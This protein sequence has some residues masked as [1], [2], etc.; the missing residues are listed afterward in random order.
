M[1]N[2]EG[3]TI[4]CSRCGEPMKS[5]ARYCMKCGNLNSN[6]EANKNMMPYIK[7]NDKNNNTYQIG[8]GKFIVGQNQSNQSREAFANNTGNKRVCFWLNYVIFIFTLL[9]AFLISKDSITD[10]TTLA[11]SPL[12]VVAIITSLYFLYVYSIELIFMK[13]NKPWWAW[14]IPVYNL[15][16]LGEIT[17]QNKKI[18]LIGLIPIIGQI[19]F[20][21]MIYKLGTQ[22]KYSGLLTVLF[23]FIFIPIIGFGSNTYDGKT[24]ITGEEKELE[25]EYKAKKIFLSTIIL[26]LGA[27]LVLMVIANMSSVE[28]SKQ[29]FGNWY[30]VSASK[31]IVNKIDKSIDKGLISCGNYEYSNTKGVYYFRFRDLSDEIY[32]PLSLLREEIDTYVKVDNNGDTTKYY[33][34][35]SD[36]TYGFSETLIDEVDMEK[37]TEYK[38]L[39]FN[40]K[41]KVICYING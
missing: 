10:F 13:C 38:Q 27:G 33:I 17:F 4:Y 24:Y 8:S 25:K 15:M 1:N 18:G 12:P 3:Y 16:I 31:R 7:D 14:F 22:F 30:Y 28:K 11:I 40:D 35:M 9:I 41:G 19:F 34:S 20:L 2:D 37:I 5:N 21:V 29:L 32:L 6:H 36:G 23:S 39:N 26:F